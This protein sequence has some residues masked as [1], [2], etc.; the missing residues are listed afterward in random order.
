MSCPRPALPSLRLGY[1]LPFV[2]LLWSLG[3][4]AKAG[5]KSLAGDRPGMAN[6][7][8]AAAGHNF[9]DDADRHPATLIDYATEVPLGQ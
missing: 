3:Y 9:A 8:A 2:Y 6:A 4:G 1:L 5:R 7:V